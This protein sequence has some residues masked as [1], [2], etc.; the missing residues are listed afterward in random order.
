M[1]SKEALEICTLIGHSK[2]LVPAIKSSPPVLF[3]SSASTPSG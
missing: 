2:L 3:L 1:N